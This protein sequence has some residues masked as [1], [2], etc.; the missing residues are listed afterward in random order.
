MNL[1]KIIITILETKLFPK[2]SVK[3]VFQGANSEKEES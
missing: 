3:D 1:I 2:W